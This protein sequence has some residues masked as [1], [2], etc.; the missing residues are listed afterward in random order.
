MKVRITY[1]VDVD[2]NFRR[3]VNEHYGRD[4]RATRAEIHRWYEANGHSMDDDLANNAD[5]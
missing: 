2:D 5:G 1:T 4:G 3:A